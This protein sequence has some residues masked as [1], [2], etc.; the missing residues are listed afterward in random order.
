MRGPEQALLYTTALNR[1]RSFIRCSARC[2][3]CGKHTT[4][5]V[6][7]AWSVG[8]FVSVCCEMPWEPQKGLQ[9]GPWHVTVKVSGHWGVSDHPGQ[10]YWAQANA[11]SS[12]NNFQGIC[13]ATLHTP[14]KLSQL[15]REVLLTSVSGREWPGPEDRPATSSRPGVTH[16]WCTHRGLGQAAQEGL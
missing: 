14:L 4:E 6:A 5:T 11:R 10:P 8:R 9:P 3:A 12:W 1:L 2:V 7:P 15:S 16:C 13:P